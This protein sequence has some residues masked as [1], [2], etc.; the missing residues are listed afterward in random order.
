MHYKSVFEG[1]PM[2]AESGSFRALGLDVPETSRCLPCVVCLKPSGAC[3][4]S[5]V[6]A[7][8]EPGQGSRRQLTDARSA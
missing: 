1:G 8:L 5:G 6:C 3:L 7:I 4:S 2:K